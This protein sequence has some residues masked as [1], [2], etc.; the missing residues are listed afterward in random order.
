[1]RWLWRKLWEFKSPCPHRSKGFKA[2]THLVLLLMPGGELQT[3][4][5]SRLLVKPCQHTWIR[6]LSKPTGAGS[7]L[8]RS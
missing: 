7:R 2:L 5:L 4:L 6:W 3:P 8:G 1:M